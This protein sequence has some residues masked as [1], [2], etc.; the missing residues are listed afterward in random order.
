MSVLI[1][2]AS[3]QDGQY[4]TRLCRDRGMDVVGCARSPGPWL[5]GDVSR[6]AD[7]ER[8]IGEYRPRHIFHLAASSTT[9]HSALF[10]NHATVST[11]TLNVLETAR[12]LVPDARVFIA[13]SGVQFANLG[14][15]ISEFDA[16]VPSSPYAMA[17]IHSVHAARYYRS[18]G[19]RTFVGYLFHH[20]SPLRRAGHVSKTIAAAAQRIG[21]GADEVLELGDI[22]VQKEWTYAP[23]TVEAMLTLVTQDEVAEATIGSGET[24]SI[25]EWLDACFATVGK[26]WRSHVRIAPGFVPEYRRL[27][28]NPSTIRSLGWAPR[29]R[30]PELARLMMHSVT[31]R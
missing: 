1:F 24:H 31:T 11:G 27:V 4:L 23:E 13:G 29:V 25:R 21:A 16:F 5:R 12:R 14:Q 17:R 9:Q 26:D 20:E 19:L 7:V 22:E 18:L 15:P 8:L 3:G 6:L 2:G 30:L 28:S 10:E